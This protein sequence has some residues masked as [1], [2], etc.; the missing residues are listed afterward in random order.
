MLFAG[1]EREHWDYGLR[2]Q[3]DVIESAAEQLWRLDRISN[4]K[5]FTFLVRTDGYV[6]RWLADWLVC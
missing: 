6:C 3:C 1:E 4:A 2:K 5:T